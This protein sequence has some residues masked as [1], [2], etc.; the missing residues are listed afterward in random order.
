MKVS[1]FMGFLGYVVISP[2]FDLF[3][4]IVICFVVNFSRFMKLSEEWFPLSV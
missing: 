3:T 1:F 4:V 2:F